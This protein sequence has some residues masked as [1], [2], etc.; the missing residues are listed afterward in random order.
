MKVLLAIDDSASSSKVL[1]E[2]ARRPWPVNS[3]IKIVS[4]YGVYLSPM[5]RP[6]FVPRHEEEILEEV[7]KHAEH[8]V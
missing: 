2:V 6:W 8:I 1:R 7:H 4:V 3:Q 5:A